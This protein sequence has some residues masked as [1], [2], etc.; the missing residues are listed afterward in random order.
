[1]VSGAGLG[2]SAEA[3]NLVAANEMA[4]ARAVQS[5]GRLRDM[6]DSVCRPA[7]APSAQPHE[8]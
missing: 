5:R 6:V 1:M 2:V 8:S 7:S 4:S 3:G